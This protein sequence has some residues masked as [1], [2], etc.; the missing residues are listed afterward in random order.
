MSGV[1]IVTIP[2]GDQEHEYL[3][4]YRPKVPPTLPDP[5]DWSFDG[6]K[7]TSA[8]V[9]ER[10]YLECSRYHPEILARDKVGRPPVPMPAVQVLTPISLRV[11]CR[12]LDLKCLRQ[13]PYRAR[14]KGCCK[15]VVLLNMVRQDGG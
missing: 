8:A 14:G 15:D 13:V 6:F 11:I 10:L 5:F 7:P 3:A 12:E 2:W 9:K 4:R 1:V